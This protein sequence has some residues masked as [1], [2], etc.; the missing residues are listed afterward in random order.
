MPGRGSDTAEAAEL[1][2]GTGDPR[3]ALIVAARIV[4]PEIVTLQVRFPPS[5]ADENRP[6]ALAILESLT[7]ERGPAADRR[8]LGRR[9]SGRAPS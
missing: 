4:G 8:P 3:Q 7:I 6:L 9:P 1:R 5:T 2:Y